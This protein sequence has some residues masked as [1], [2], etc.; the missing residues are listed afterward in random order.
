MTSGLAQCSFCGVGEYSSQGQAGCDSCSRVFEGLSSQTGSAE[1]RRCASG[2]YYD[3]SVESAVWPPSEKNRSLN[4]CTK[5]EFVSDPERRGQYLEVN[6]P[7]PQRSDMDYLRLGVNC[8][9]PPTDTNP[10][11]GNPDDREGPGVTLETLPVRAGFYRFGATSEFVY[12]CRSPANCK[13]SRSLVNFTR[14]N[15][16]SWGDALCAEGAMG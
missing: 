7:D 8:Y 14:A 3:A 13:G 4:P 11:T 15:N 12:K 1:C 6:G 9:A 5:C 2:Y 10:S 16:D